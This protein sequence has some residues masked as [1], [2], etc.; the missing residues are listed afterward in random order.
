MIKTAAFPGAAVL[1]CEGGEKIRKLGYRL[2]SLAIVDS[3]NAANK[4]IK[5]REQN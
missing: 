5:F 3:M 4:T 2:E 1:L